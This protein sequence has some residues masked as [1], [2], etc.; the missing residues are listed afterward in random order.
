MVY[1]QLE[2]MGW[3]EEGDQDEKPDRETAGAQENG[4]GRK[5]QTEGSE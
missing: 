2:E 4:R 5:R 1:G 3:K